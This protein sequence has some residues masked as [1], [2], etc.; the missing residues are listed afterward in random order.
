MEWFKIYFTNKNFFLS[1]GLVLYSVTA[2]GDGPAI[3]VRIAEA[4]GNIKV[5]G[6]NIS[7]TLIGNKK[8][9]FEGEKYISFNC[10]GVGSDIKVNKPIE[11]S[12]I[13]SESNVLLWDGKRYKG[14]MH[15]VVRERGKGCDLINE[16]PLE[17]YISTV[18]AKE[19]NSKWPLEALKAQAV[20][21]R[22][23]AF[24]KKITKQ[25]NQEKGHE[26][27]YDLENSQ[28]HQVNGSYSDATAKTLRAA[29]ETSGEVLALKSG[30]LTPVFY[31]SKCGGKTLTPDQV[32][33]ESIQGYVS[34][35]CPFCHT[36]G[37]KQ[38]EKKLPKNTFL[39]LVK[40]AMSFFHKKNIFISQANA[41]IVPDSKQNTVLRFYKDDQLNSVQKSRI[42]QLMGASKLLSNYYHV[43]DQGNFVTLYG[44]GYGHGVGMCQYG[45]FELAK[46]GYNYKQIL[47]HYFP[48]H[49]IKK[50]Y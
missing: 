32:W 18:L 40:K 39:R 41:K 9:T 37:K 3:R 7:R 31:H 24:H 15:V 25:V 48:E 2:F 5:G 26:T 45:A 50:L 14:K 19:M 20:A 47:A 38:W 23:Y 35:D 6:E 42:R 43:E 4:H 27:F 46:R 44:K 34:V 28:K 36:H 29:K 12:T 11:F 33:D 17:V 49:E 22:S 1:I 16:L 13:Y 8:K 10:D 30:M 21:A